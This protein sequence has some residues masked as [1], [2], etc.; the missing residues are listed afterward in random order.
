MK[1]RILI[2]SY[3]IAIC[4]LLL[5]NVS[6]ISTNMG[7][8]YRPGE[9]A[10]VEL[11]GN[12]LEPIAFGNVMI[13]RNNVLM[14][15]DYDVKKL[16]ERY[17]IWFSSPRDEGN[18]TLWIKNL[19]TTVNGV[20][21]VT[22]FSQNFSVK[23]N[24]ID[25]SVSPGF[26]MTGNNFEINVKVY[27]DNDIPIAVDFPYQQQVLL[28]PGDNIIDFDVSSINGSKFSTIHLGVYALPIY[29]MKNLSI[30]NP[31]IT[32]SPL[33]ISR[34]ILISE[35]LP[36]Y[37]IISVRNL[38]KNTLNNVYFE[39]DNSSV[40]INSSKFNIRGNETLKFNLSIIKGSDF[41][42]QVNLIYG[43]YSFDFPIG[44][45]FEKNNASGNTSTGNNLYRCSELR[46][47]ICSASE[48]CSTSQEMSL[49]GP[50]CTGE[51]SIPGSGS[52]SYSWLGYL[53]VL[54]VLVVGGYVYMNYRKAKG[55]TNPVAAAAH[56]G[57][58]PPVQR[59][60]GP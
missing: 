55:V 12:I 15:Q 58:H 26:M 21:S 24:F 54:I 20:P 14:A 41:N 2:G 39:Y 33:S 13:K 53:V 43:N 45:V 28:K 18:Y 9:T 34:I 8:D 25:Y 4:F 46:G 10:V 57:G 31:E 30:E 59:K 7:G 17:Y 50:C 32:F 29:V 1:K 49:D 16:G 22:D 27:G 5:V 40:S 47:K 56:A 3:L 23:G 60:P 36:V 42:T 44:V 52:S 38:G 37:N 51:C 19:K 35:K 48:V 6:A 11:S